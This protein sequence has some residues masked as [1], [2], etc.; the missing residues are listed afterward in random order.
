M[1]RNKKHKM[2]E[3]QKSPLLRAMSPKEVEKIIFAY[4]T[5]RNNQATKHKEEV[6]KLPREG[7]MV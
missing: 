1:N 3:D 6:Y 4:G 5:I 2:N 7:P